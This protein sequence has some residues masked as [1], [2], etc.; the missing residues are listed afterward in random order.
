MTTR[1]LTGENTTGHEISVSA[2]IDDAYAVL[3]AEAAEFVRAAGPDSVYLS[4][5]SYREP[6]DEYVLLLFTG[7]T[8]KAP[9]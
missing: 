8:W 2:A 5:I 3:L 7:E 4:G 1:A 9:E 6:E